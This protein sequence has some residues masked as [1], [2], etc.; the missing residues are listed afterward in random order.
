[1]IWIGADFNWFEHTHR[2][3]M[4]THKI[5]ID[6]I[7]NH[8][9]ILKNYKASSK[10]KNLDIDDSSS[11]SLIRLSKIKNVRSTICSNQDKTKINIPHVKN[12]MIANNF[13]S[14]LFIKVIM[15][16][17]SIFKLGD[18]SSCLIKCSKVLENIKEKIM[19]DSVVRPLKIFWVKADYGKVG[20]IIAFLGTGL[21]MLLSNI[22]KRTDFSK[23]IQQ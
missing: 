9:K 17:E 5:F 19:I 18:C 21:A 22:L 13:N 1:M 12:Y 15:A 2:D 8:P 10:S 7:L 4:L 20:R 3:W 16:D 14:E 11:S 6:E 23:Y